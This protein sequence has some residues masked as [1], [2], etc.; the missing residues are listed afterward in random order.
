MEKMTS[1]Y[2]I[3]HSIFPFWQQLAAQQFYQTSEAAD[4]ENASSSESNVETEKT[5]TDELWK[6][7]QE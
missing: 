7:I 5:T 3:A 6:A 2:T 1:E 4:T